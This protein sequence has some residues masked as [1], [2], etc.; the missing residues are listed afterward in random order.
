MRNLFFFYHEHYFQIV[1]FIFY[2]I[3]IA[4]LTCCSGVVLFSQGKAVDIM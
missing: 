3:E 1:L 2:V 4:A